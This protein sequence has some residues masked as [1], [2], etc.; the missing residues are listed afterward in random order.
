MFDSMTNPTC[1]DAIH[2]SVDHIL[3]AVMG[4]AGM[5][6]EEARVLFDKVPQASKDDLAK[7]FTQVCVKMLQ[8]IQE[9]L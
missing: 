2:E 3:A 9:E 8:N 1:I 5:S 6:R 4:A 7:V